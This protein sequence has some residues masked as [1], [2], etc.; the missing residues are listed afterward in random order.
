MSE[1]ASPENVEQRRHE[2]EDDS[3]V[4]L[5][6][7]EVAKL[8]GVSR[9]LAYEMM[10]TGRLPVVR[11]GRAVRVP[12]VALAEWIRRKTESAA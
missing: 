2:V 10:A 3:V 6:A 5:R 9:S 7:V 1:L 8:L 4:L 11:I 12:K